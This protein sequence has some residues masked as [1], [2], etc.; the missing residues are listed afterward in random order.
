MIPVLQASFNDQQP[1]RDTVQQN[2]V[3]EDILLIHKETL[4][5]TQSH[6]RDPIPVRTEPSVEVRPS[7]SNPTISNP[8]L[9]NSSNDAQPLSPQRTTVDPLQQLNSVEPTI[10]TPATPVRVDPQQQTIDTVPKVKTPDVQEQQQQLP[11]AAQNDTTYHEK[12]PTVEVTAAPPTVVTTEQIK[13]VEVVTVEKK[14][15]VEVTPPP[16][17]LAT[18]ERIKPVEA[19][20]VEK[21]LEDDSVAS[22]RMPTST[23]TPP[24]VLREGTSRIQQKAQAQVRHRHDRVKQESVKPVVEKSIPNPGKIEKDRFRPGLDRCFVLEPVNIKDVP[25]STATPIVEIPS[26]TTQAPEPREDSIQPPVLEQEK[27]DETPSLIPEPTT[28]P[29]DDVDLPR[30]VHV[31]DASALL[32]EQLQQEEER[33]EAL[34]DEIEQNTTSSSFLAHESTSH[35]PR[36]LENDDK[37]STIETLTTTVVAPVDHPTPVNESNTNPFQTESKV[38]SIWPRPLLDGFL[39]FFASR[40]ARVT[41]L[42]YR[43]RTL[44]SRMP[45]WTSAIK[46]HPRIFVKCAGVYQRLWTPVS[47]WWRIRCSVS[48]IS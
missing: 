24:R 19:V 43:K 38:C 13:P 25:T 32:Q 1:S 16:P 40:T 9:N 2:L 18:P 7:V 4:V 6:P 23:Q 14:P 11:P 21:K 5:T 46:R 33:R 36:I 3:K 22:Q 15:L 28:E 31:H 17:T 44:L 42:I 41:M 48:W 34:R 29:V 8:V 10:V 47:A 20:N 35:L 45:W 39:I 26:I 27:V 12:R 30:L 37:L